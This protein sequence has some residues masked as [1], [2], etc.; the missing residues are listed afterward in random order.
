M[1]TRLLVN[2]L[3]GRSCKVFSSFILNPISENLFIYN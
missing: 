3:L 1:K 2:K